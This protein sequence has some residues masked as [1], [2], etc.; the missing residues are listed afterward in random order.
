V[1]SY[2][3]PH[4]GDPGLMFPPGSLNT[5]MRANYLT[6]TLSGKQGMWGRVYSMGDKWNA[7]ATIKCGTIWST[8]F[9]PAMDYKVP[10]NDASGTLDWWVSTGKNAVYDEVHFAKEWRVLHYQ[11]QQTPGLC[12]LQSVV[13]G[14]PN[15][16][17]WAEKGTEVI[18]V[19]GP[20]NTKINFGSFLGV[21]RAGGTYAMVS[22][23][24]SGGHS[25]PY[26]EDGGDAT[27]KDIRY[28]WH[29]DK[30]HKFG[31]Q[32]GLFHGGRGEFSGGDT[33]VFH[34]SIIHMHN[35]KKIRFP[36]DRKL[37]LHL[38]QSSDCANACR[39]NRSSETIVMEYDV[40]NAKSDKGYLWAL[41]GIY[42]HPD[43]GDS[44]ATS[45]AALKERM[46]NG[47]MIDGSYSDAKDNVTK[48]KLVEGNQSATVN[49]DPGTGYTLQYMIDY[50]LVTY[51]KGWD[52]VH[53]WH[54]AKLTP[55]AV[56]VTR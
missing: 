13:P 55:Y 34:Y 56:Y 20:D 23:D 53:F 43:G 9:M 48:T 12:E 14:S 46:K 19:M 45:Y 52:A 5:L 50:Q 2:S 39:N 31:P 11:Y 18:E 26:R 10:V 38:G 30:N 35:R 21:Q 1:L 32:I 36:D 29:I 7:A 24:W 3:E 33:K 6:M 22:G 40:Q 25:Q 44:K 51:T 27:K 47:V 4:F 54:R 37:T 42:L 49:V 28:T 16:I 17:P 8:S 41:A 15:H